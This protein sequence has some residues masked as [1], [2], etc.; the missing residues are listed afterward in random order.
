MSEVTLAQLKD[1]SVKV[2]EWSGRY[3]IEK[4]VYEDLYL[5]HVKVHQ[6]IENNPAHFKSNEEHNEAFCLSGYI[7]I[8]LLS[9]INEFN[10]N[11]SL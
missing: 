11:E 3:D 2:E 5:E 6:F 1:L 9:R 4:S 7:S 8:C 10:D